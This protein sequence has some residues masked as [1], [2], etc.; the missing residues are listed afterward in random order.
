[1]VNFGDLVALAQ[2]YNASL[3]GAPIAGASGDFQADLAAAFAPEPDAL[4]ALALLAPLLR[5]RRQR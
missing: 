4:A 1:V 3:P 5:R 2:H